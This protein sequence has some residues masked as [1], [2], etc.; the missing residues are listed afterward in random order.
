MTRV[1]G[2]VDASLPDAVGQHP[3]LQ[4]RRLLNGVDVQARAH[5]PRNVAMERPHAR[6]VGLI[7]QHDIA[8]RLHELHVA[9]L[10]VG[11]VDDLAV[12]SA[13]ALGQ[14]VEIVTM[15]MHGVGGRE[16]VV[17]DDADGAVVPK[18]V[19]VPFGIEGVGEVALVGQDE[20]G[21][22]L[23]GWGLAMARFG[24][25]R[26]LTRSCRGKTR[27]SYRRGSSRWRSARR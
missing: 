27:R 3:F 13:D 21:V 23:G 8:K 20:D 11:L 4:Q 5:V 6:V 16:V 7:L 2:P 14:D 1:V 25:E 9:A 15:E 26:R 10:G 18:V 24:R 17:D 22:A 19:D 12:P